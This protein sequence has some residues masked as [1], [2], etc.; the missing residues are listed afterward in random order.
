[1]SLKYFTSYPSGNNG[2][3]GLQ[4]A[5]TGTGHGNCR[6]R[7]STASVNPGSRPQSVVGPSHPFMPG[8]AA[9]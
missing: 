4:E 8:G 9:Y 3:L 2:R 1:M 6:L 7:V 5:S